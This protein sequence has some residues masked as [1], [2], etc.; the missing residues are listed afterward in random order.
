MS[1]NLSDDTIR[2]VSGKT[3]SSAEEQILG[4]QVLEAGKLTRRP[5]ERGIPARTM[6]FGW[7]LWLLFK[8]GRGVGIG[9]FCWI[10]KRRE[11]G[12]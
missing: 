3:V 1:F 12:E 2:L 9:G 10:W 8:D 7:R 4:K 6:W 5:L 11:R